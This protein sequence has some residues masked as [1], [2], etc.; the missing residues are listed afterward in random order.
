MSSKNAR[1]EPPT[2]ARCSKKAR[3]EP[4]TDVVVKVGTGDKMQ[5]FE[6]H[7]VLLRLASEVFEAMLTSPMKEA[8]TRTIANQQL[9]RKRHVQRETRMSNTLPKK[10]KQPK[11]M[12]PPLPREATTK[13]CKQWVRT[14]PG[15]TTMW[16]MW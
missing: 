14:S 5:E 11:A 3:S 4:P 12:H 13:G 1:T 9:D 16:L 6:C 2:D 8:T 15:T 7:S 10:T